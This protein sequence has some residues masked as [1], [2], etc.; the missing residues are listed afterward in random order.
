MADEAR[1][2]Y[3]NPERTVYI[4]WAK[5]SFALVGAPRLPDVDTDL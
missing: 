2:F 3:R 1:V 5:L 4:A